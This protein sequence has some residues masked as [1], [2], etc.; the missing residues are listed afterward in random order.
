MKDCLEELEVANYGAV[1]RQ[2]TNL[3]GK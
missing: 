2:N 1:R 3:N